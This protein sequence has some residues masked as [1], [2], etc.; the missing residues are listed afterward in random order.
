MWS[1][2]SHHQATGLKEV[3]PGVLGCPEQPEQPEQ[4]G[5]QWDMV[6][7]K[8]GDSSSWQC[9]DADLASGCLTRHSLLVE[10]IAAHFA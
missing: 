5:A 8:P 1:T 2:A 3:C 4:T 7:T 6:E 10:V 9:E